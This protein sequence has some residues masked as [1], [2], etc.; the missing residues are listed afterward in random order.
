MLFSTQ[1]VVQSI[2][3]KQTHSLSDTSFVSVSDVSM[4]GTSND[5]DNKSDKQTAQIIMNDKSYTNK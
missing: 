2:F 5:N 1:S 4:S 3:V